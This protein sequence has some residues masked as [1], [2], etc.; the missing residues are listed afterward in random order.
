MFPE[1]AGKPLEEIDE[2]FASKVP[3]WKTHV[4]TG[5]TTA[6]EHGDKMGKR[7]SHDEETAIGE[8]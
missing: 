3:A 1:T 2:L 5:E 7:I 8:K 6:L 4:Q